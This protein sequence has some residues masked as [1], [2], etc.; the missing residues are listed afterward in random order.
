MVDSWQFACREFEE[1]L[2]AHGRE[3]S[4]SI[5]LAATPLMIVSSS[6]SS[7][8]L[9]QS[10][11][12]NSSEENYAPPR[13]LMSFPILAELM[14]SFLTSLND[15]R[16]CVLSSLNFR[17]SKCLQSSIAA[18]IIS[19]GEFCQQNNVHLVEEEEEEEEKEGKKI[20]TVAIVNPAAGI[21]SIPPTRNNSSSASGKSTLHEQMKGIVEVQHVNMIL[22]MY[23][24]DTNISLM[25]TYR[26]FN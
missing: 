8:T 18:V 25:N 9:T 7:F 4:A 17:L 2:N 3:N 19:I 13:R 16:L 14:N 21:G 23:L 15:L 24:S 10:S 6:S 1:N 11:S 22:N 5:R 26:L 12:C 20:K